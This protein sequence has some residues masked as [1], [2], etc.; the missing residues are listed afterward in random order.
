MS[1]QQ[2]GYSFKNYHPELNQFGVQ[3][4]GIEPLN[5]TNLVFCAYKN[6]FFLL[7]E[8]PNIWKHRLVN[9]YADLSIPLINVL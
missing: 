3:Q 6:S 2:N 7:I 9:S 4:S 1:S 5:P 8:V